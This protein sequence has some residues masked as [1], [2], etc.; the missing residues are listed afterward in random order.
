MCCDKQSTQTFVPVVHK[1]V[2]G[3]G[4]GLYW[5]AV[6]LPQFSGEEMSL[7]CE[8]VCALF[9]MQGLGGA[10]VRRCAFP[11]L[12]D[13]TRM[14]LETCIIRNRYHSLMVSALPPAAYNG[15]FVRFSASCWAFWW[16][17]NGDSGCHL[18]RKQEERWDPSFTCQETGTWHGEYRECSFQEWQITTRGKRK[19]NCPSEEKLLILSFTVKKER[20]T[21]SLILKSRH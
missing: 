8:S 16:W 10:S 12:S 14:R 13:K 9:N 18:G 21:M 17:R 7:V 15:P 5:Q 4:V 3:F 19:K 6:F 20:K 11:F 2:N 1:L